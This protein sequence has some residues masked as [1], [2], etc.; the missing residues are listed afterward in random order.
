VATAYDA[1]TNVGLV[2]V[3]YLAGESILRIF[4]DDPA[5]VA[6]ALDY[7]RV[8][9]PSYLALGVGIVLGNAMTGAGATRTTFAIDALVILLLQLP[10]C[11][12]VVGPLGG[13][14]RALFRCVAAVNVASAIAYA[15]VY[16][17]RRWLEASARAG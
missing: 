8:V 4:D 12:V 15:L 5:P 11:L 9:A 2:V 3:V 16:S 17:R 1:I 13:S 14:L 7:L 6:I 10:L